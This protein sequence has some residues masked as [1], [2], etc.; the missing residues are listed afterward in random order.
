MPVQT[1]W[2]ATSTRIQ[3]YPKH[4]RNNH[5]YECDATRLADM[6]LQQLRIQFHAHDE[7]VESESDVSD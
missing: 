2:S 4:K 5:P 1:L 6:G 3:T 7:Q